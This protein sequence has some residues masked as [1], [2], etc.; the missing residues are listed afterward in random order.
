MWRT[1]RILKEFSAKDLAIQASTETV[2]VAEGEAKTY[3]HYLHKAGY[4]VI[5]SPH[6]SGN[7]SMTG[8]LARYRL[9]ISKFSGPKPPVIQRIKQVFDPNAGKVVWKGGT[10][11]AE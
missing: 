10:D 7:R 2:K 8:K 11:D 9:I 3:V 6:R 5:V 1:M 4:L